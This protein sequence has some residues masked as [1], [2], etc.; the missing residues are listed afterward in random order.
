MP[1]LQALT[2]N[3]I[4]SCGMRYG[5]KKNHSRI[6]KSDSVRH[7]VQTHLDSCSIGEVA[8]EL[9]YYVISCRKLE[10]ITF[11][12]SPGLYDLTS[13][14]GGNKE[15]SQLATVCNARGINLHVENR[16]KTYSLQGLG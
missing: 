5:R 7:L 15:M 1:N 9:L 16:K 6:V 8:L 12:G 2:T 13:N 3:F 11:V 10:S 14:C 4:D